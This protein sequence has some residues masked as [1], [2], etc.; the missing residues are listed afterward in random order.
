MV[1]CVV[2]D[3]DLEFVQE[4][5]PQVA[6]L[7]V[8]IDLLLGENLL[9]ADVHLS[10]LRRR[11]H[12]DVGVMRA[13]VDDALEAVHFSARRDVNVHNGSAVVLKNLW[14]EVERRRQHG[15][16]ADG[17]DEVA[18]QMGRRSL[19][20]AN[21]RTIVQNAQEDVAAES[22]QKRTDGLID[23][24]FYA[25]AATLELHRR[26]LANGKDRFQVLRRQHKLT[27]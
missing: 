1:L 18:N 10:N 5:Q 4:I 21:H 17:A 8:G 23:I 27:P 3:A 15:W 22:V 16:V 26:G 12:L 11:R 2:D 13:I 14:R 6:Q 24:V 20:H 9:L 25:I 19:G 7:H